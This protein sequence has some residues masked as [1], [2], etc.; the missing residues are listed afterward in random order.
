MP[1]ESSSLTW[2]SLTTGDAKAAADLL[3]AMEAVDQIG[4]LYTEEDTL[5][6]LIDP[7]LD[8]ERASFGVFD[9]D[10]MV[11]DMKVSYKPATEEVHR[12]LINGGVHPDYRRRGIGTALVEAGVAAAKALH[13]QHDPG[14]R[15]AIDLHWAE[16]IAGAAELFRSQGFAPAWYDQQ[17][18]HPLGDAIPETAVPDGLRVEPWSQQ[19]DEEFRMIRN[20]AFKDAGLAEM[21]VDSWKNRMT[22]HTFRPEA[23]FLL[24]DVANGAPAGVLLT[25]C[26]EADAAATGFRDA[27]FFLIG[28]LRNYRRRGVAGA[29]IGHALRAAADQGYDRAVL[30]VGSATPTGAFGIYEKAGFV[31]GLRFVRWGLES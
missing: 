7:Y 26:W 29:L 13:T 1:E 21:P 4:Q 24:R 16:H 22:D 20:E 5:Q 11:G 10:V 6:E 14:T 19:N 12:V 23:S 28:T 17:M 2:R 25:K 9:D 30:R 18:E 31:P 3:N 15:L 27:T 8:L